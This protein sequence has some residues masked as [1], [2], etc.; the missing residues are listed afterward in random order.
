MKNIWY[1]FLRTYAQLGFFFFYKKIKVTGKE[2]IPFDKPVMFVSNHPNALIDPLLVATTNHR[3]TYF[4]TRAAVFKPGLVDWFMRSANMLPVYRIRDGLSTVKKNEAIF[5]FSFTLLK[6]KLALLI[7][8]EGSHSLERRVRPL[9]KGFTRVVFGALEEYPDLDIAIVPIGI[10]YNSPT[11]YGSKVSLIY[12]PPIYVN[13]FRSEDPNIQAI[14]LTKATSDALKEIVCHIE[15]PDF[16]T[17]VID[18]D[19]Y[20]N[21][22]EFNEKLMTGNLNSV[23]NNTGKRFNFFGLLFKLNSFLPLLFWKK[24]Q[25]EIEEEEFIATYKYSIGI[26]VFP[27]IYVLQA[28]ILG[29]FFGKTMAWIY[30]ISSLAVALIYVKTK[31]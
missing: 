28:I 1:L 29:A 8:A 22:V 21:P 16:D 3:T 25:K 6:E 15:D 23:P 7:F 26:T 24:K 19:E 10:N 27:I 9:S 4:F 11:E 18:K 13:N 20:L 14:E 2:N 31:K 17:S 5:E 12:A 30:L